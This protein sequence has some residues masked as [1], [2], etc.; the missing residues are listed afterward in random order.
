MAYDSGHSIA[1]YARGWQCVGKLTNAGTIVACQLEAR[2]TL[3]GERA[4]HVNTAV[5]AVPVPTLV[6]V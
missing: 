4:G 3:A 5:L 6:N 1:G 2:L